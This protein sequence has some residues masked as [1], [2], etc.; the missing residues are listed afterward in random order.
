MLKIRKRPL[1]IL[2]F[3]F[4]YFSLKNNSTTSTTALPIYCQNQNLMN[5]KKIH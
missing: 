4:F 3:R 5:W 2:F 1:K